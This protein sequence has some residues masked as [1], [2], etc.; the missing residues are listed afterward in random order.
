LRLVV[1]RLYAWKSAKWVCGIEL[2][3][4]DR[5]GFWERN[6]YHDHGDP[7]AEGRFS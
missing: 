6:G 3:A 4:D 7:W 1:P 5:P 2:L